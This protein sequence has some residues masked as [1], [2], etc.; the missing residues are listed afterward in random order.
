MCVALLFYRTRRTRAQKKK[1]S[2]VSFEAQR[3]KTFV[4]FL[5]VNRKRIRNIG[6]LR[7]LAKRGRSSSSKSSAQKACDESL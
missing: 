4:V 6:G 1:K 2:G 3:T 7:P 5:K